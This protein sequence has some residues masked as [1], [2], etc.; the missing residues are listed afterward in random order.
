[1]TYALI[2]AAGLVVNV[3]LLDDPTDY[4][5]PS[6]QRLIK[7]PAGTAAGIG[8]TYVNGQFIAPPDPEPVP[9]TPDEQRAARL[10][11]YTRE[12]DPLYF[13]TQR[14]EA[15]IEEWEAKVA[16][17]RARYPMPLQD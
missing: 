10:A 5:P 6:G 14:G 12:A 3:I 16:E 7:I 2:N 9:P 8:W 11:A 13:K 1:M 17:I 15:T 4:T